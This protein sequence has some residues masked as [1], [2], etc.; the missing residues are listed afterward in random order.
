MLSLHG[1][2]EKI[3]TAYKTQD[4]FYKKHAN[5]DFC[6]VIPNSQTLTMK[7]CFLRER[8]RTKKQ[9]IISEARQIATTVTEKDVKVV[10]VHVS[11]ITFNVD[12]NK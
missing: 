3:A 5:F 9:E 6:S 4:H 10:L 12:C 11:S 2:T 8:E 7:K 1:T